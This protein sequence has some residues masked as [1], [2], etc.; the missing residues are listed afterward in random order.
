MNGYLLCGLGAAVAWGSADFCAKKAATAFGFWPTVWAMNAVGALAM[1]GVW[2]GGGVV[3]R[4][5]HLPLLIALALGNALGGVFFY[6]ALEHGPLALVS[7]ITAAYPVVSAV[8]AFALAGERLGPW[9]LAAVGGVIAGTLL[10]SMG[11]GSDKR[12]HPR[13][14][15]ALLA[16]VVSAFVFGAVFFAL[17]ANASVTSATAPVL[18]FRWVGAIALALPLFWGWRLPP[19]LWRSGWIWATGLL[20][21]F[22]YLLYAEGG[23]HLPVSIIS[24]LSG[25]FTVWTLVLAVLFLRERLGWRQWI[26]VGLILAGI[27]ALVF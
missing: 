7:P 14:S 22:A 21:S 1:A 27:A 12:D 6:F 9:L 15:S 2:A 19:A 13:G 20:D 26:G 11:A 5:A 18:V 10:A 23:K 4:I 16:A 25:L 17:A 3:V 24:A 8:L